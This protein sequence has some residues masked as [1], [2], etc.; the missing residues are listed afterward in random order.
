VLNEFPKNSRATVEF[1]E[2]SANSYLSRYESGRS[3]STRIEMI[4][5]DIVG[6]IPIEVVGGK[7]TL[8]LPS[9]QGMRQSFEAY[10]GSTIEWE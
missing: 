8:I 5:E 4:L 1:L 7:R 9:L 3:T 6:K 2:E 10:L